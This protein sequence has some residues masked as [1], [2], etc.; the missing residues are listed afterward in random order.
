MQRL[1]LVMLW[2]L[3]HAQGLVSRVPNQAL[4]NCD[5]SDDDDELAWCLHPA[6]S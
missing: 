6:G 4:E 1:L 3:P 2:L 5:C